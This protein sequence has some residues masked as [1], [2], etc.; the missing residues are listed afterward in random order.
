MIMYVMLSINVSE[1]EM[2]FRRFVCIP[3]RIS[4]LRRVPSVIYLSE[5]SPDIPAVFC[6][7]IF[8]LLGIQNGLLRLRFLVCL[9]L[10]CLGLSSASV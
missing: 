8:V 10:V 2:I 9:S 1:F 7:L 3:C 6:C 5:P 4:S